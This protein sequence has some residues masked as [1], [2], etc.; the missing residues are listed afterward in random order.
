MRAYNG[1]YVYVNRSLAEVDY[2]VT[3]RNIKGQK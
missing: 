3:G 1:N 2:G